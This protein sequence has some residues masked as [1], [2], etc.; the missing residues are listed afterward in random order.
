MLLL[1]T[2]KTNADVLLVVLVD[3]VGV[4]VVCGRLLLLWFNAGWR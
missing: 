2:E 4:V 3:V 1:S